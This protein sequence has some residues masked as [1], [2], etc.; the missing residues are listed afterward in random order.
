MRLAGTLTALYIA[1]CS[2][3][4]G[5]HPIVFSQSFPAVTSAGPDSGLLTIAGDCL[6]DLCGEFDGT[7]TDVDVVFIFGG[8]EMAL[9]TSVDITGEAGQGNQTLEAGWPVTDLDRIDGQLTFHVRRTSFN[10]F[11]QMVEV[12]DSDPLFIDVL[13]D[14]QLQ[15]PN[16]PMRIAVRNANNNARIPNAWVIAERTDRP[17]GASMYLNPV[18]GTGGVYEL[19]NANVIPYDVS[20]HAAGFFPQTITNVMPAGDGIDQ[21]F[22][23]TPDPGLTAPGTVDVILELSSADL[24]GPTHVLARDAQIR[25]GGVDIGVEP[26]FAHGFLAFFGVPAGSYVLHVPDTNDFMFT[27]TPFTL[28]TGQRKSIEVPVEPANAA[29]FTRFTGVPGQIAGTV[30]ATTG[31]PTPL[32]GAHVISSQSG[33]DY[34]T[35]SFSV[36]GGTYFIAD[37]E[38][39][40]GLI[41]AFSPDGSIFGPAKEADVVDGQ[42]FGDEI[43]EDAELDVPIDAFDQDANGLP[44]DFEA[45]YLDGKGLTAEEAGIDGDP[46]DDGLTNLEEATAQTDPLDP[47]SD[48]DGFDD[49]MEVVL[50]SNP[51]SGGSTPT[52]PNPVYIDF[53]IDNRAEAGSLGFPFADLDSAVEFAAPGATIR[54]K[55]DVDV[56]VGPVPDAAISK[57]LTIRSFNGNVSIGN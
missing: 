5:A 44:D 12:Q 27:D 3:A 13:F 48:N 36:D 47:D 49:G 11:T 35:Y 6:D 54:I 14:N 20:V 28:G 57:Q 51:N 19:L 8:F 30:T 2:G 38:P 32:E 9:A 15:P 43:D 53:G 52:I 46:D 18:A 55:G 37:A 10:N 39:G 7:V 17:I 45:T 26:V 50:G 40:L 24:Y 1:L 25:S 41:Q 16:R 4:A 31:S 21:E 34:S 22:L 33:S 29:K 56:L 23:L 42:V